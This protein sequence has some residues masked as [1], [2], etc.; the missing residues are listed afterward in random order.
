MRRYCG[1]IVLVVGAVALV[2]SGIGPSVAVAA[3]V[4]EKYGRP[5]RTTD[6]LLRDGAKES[7]KE[8]K[9]AADSVADLPVPAT[10]GQFP[11][12]GEGNMEPV[13]KGGQGGGG[14]SGGGGPGGAEPPKPHWAV[15]VNI[16][17][18][19]FLEDETTDYNF[20]P[21]LGEIGKLKVK[22]SPTPPAGSF[23][24]LAIQRQ[25]SG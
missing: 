10:A 19:E 11:M 3:D 6:T 7:T 15:V 20:S 2:L 1:A 8:K 17:K 16:L 12:Y 18:V 22:V 13:R 21:S 24:D 9:M 4:V 23:T 25:R 14:G 5:D